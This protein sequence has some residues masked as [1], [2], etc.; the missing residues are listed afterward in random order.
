MEQ[1]LNTVSSVHN[2]LR[3]ILPPDLLTQGDLHYF[4]GDCQILSQS[5]DYFSF[6]VTPDGA[7]AREISIIKKDP[8]LFPVEDK[9]QIDWDA[10][11]IA[12]LQLMKTELKSLEPHEY[13]EH[14][15]YSREGMIQR[16]LK[17]RADKAAKADYRVQ[18]ADNIY[19]DHILTNENGVKYK[20]FLRDFEKETGYSDSMDAK[21][22]KLGT[23]KH[24]MYA[25]RQLKEN[26]KL[27]NALKK[28]CP[29]V[30][31]YL[32]PL[33]DYAISWFFTG[34][35]PLQIQM[36]LSKYFGREN[37]ISDKQIPEFLNF[38]EEAQNHPEIRIRPEV[39]EKIES[40]YEKKVLNDLQET[41]QADFSMLDATLYPYQ[42]E[43]IQ[44]T[45]FRKA[46]ILADDMGLGKTI[47][48]IGTAINKKAFFGFNR[49]LIVCPASL[50]SQWKKEI[51]K[52]TSEEAVVAEGTPRERAELH[53]N[54]KAF[55]VI[56]NYEAVMRDQEAINQSEPDFMILDEAQRVKNFATKTAGAIGRIN[57]KHALAITGTPIENRLIDIFSIVNIMEPGFLG[58]LWEFSY[59]HCLFD[60]VKHDKING[61]Y[62]LQTLKERIQP[63]LLRRE[64]RNVLDQ[65][66]NL[67]QI[68]IPVGFSPVQ[69]DYHATY[70]RG[71]SQIVRKKILTPFD[72]KRLQLLLT[73][74]R[75]VCDSSFLVDETTHDS[76]KLEELKFLLL[77]KL[78]VKKKKQ[79]IIIFSEWVKMLKI[80]GRML[81]ENGIGFVELTGSVPVKNRG[82]LISRFEE[83]DNVQVFLSSE[84]GG[85]GLNLQ[86]ADTL[87]NFE[88]PWNPAKKNQRIGR[89]NRIG[90]TKKHLT[91]LNFITKNSIEERIAAGLEVKQNLF[92]GVLDEDSKTDMV[93]FSEKGRSQF[94][95]QIE[96]FIDKYEEP[97]PEDKPETEEERISQ[98]EEASTENTQ[99]E[100]IDLSGDTQTDEKEKVPKQET[101]EDDHSP[102]GEEFEQVMN[103]GLQ[104]L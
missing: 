51:E 45:T 77:E 78:E 26:P 93:D 66:P 41:E 34:P 61:Y 35:L 64:K 7:T 31:I 73:S 57:K 69:A 32:D 17:E 60:P 104:F 54:S 37:F 2:K 79:K 55:F 65:L 68:N 92:D 88:L 83:D 44:F 90:Q 99:E 102:S 24:L 27:Y 40:F 39:P 22:N 71:V 87:V 72:L 8:E 53:K 80:I 97:V 25:F 48:S 4:N 28:E 47:Q 89:I 6:L 43:G 12:C 9:K 42:K 52:F 13:I 23:T 96:S 95:K 18:W 21:T 63:L 5:A 56:T 10:A 91:I 85:S 103:N 15:K 62:D 84:A 74:M 58:P 81:R 59:Q 82:A 19:G 98:P 11:A 29:F 14:K 67:R 100:P 33:N 30:E 75:M 1:I 16:V 101:A 46:A 50:K 38:I 20:L 70:A 94:L 49:T 86:V 3:S 36:L 76:P